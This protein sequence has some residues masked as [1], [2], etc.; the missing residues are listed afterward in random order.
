MKKMLI[1]LLLST[2]GL[3]MQPVEIDPIHKLANLRDN[4]QA[5]SEEI[6]IHISEMLKRYGDDITMNNEQFKALVIQYFKKESSTIESNIMP[7]LERKLRDSDSDIQEILEKDDKVKL[8]EF[9]HALVTDSIEEAFKEKDLKYDELKQI[10]DNRLKR[11]RYA[12][13]TAVVSGVC[14][15]LTVFFGVYFGRG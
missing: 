1:V 5:S 3:A 9:I 6:A 14:G 10:A 13:I 15:A 4:P 12:L 2:R 11:A 7:H 8:R